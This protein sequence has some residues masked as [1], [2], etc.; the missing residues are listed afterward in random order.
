MKGFCP[1]A[2]R[3]HKKSLYISL[4]LFF[5][6]SLFWSSRHIPTSTQAF[7]AVLHAGS[8]SFGLPY[9]AAILYLIRLED[10]SDLLDSLASVKR[11]LPGPPWPVILFH[12]GDFDEEG[13]RIE[14]VDNVYNHL[15]ANNASKEFTERIEF[16]KLDWRLPEGISPDVNVVNPVFAHQWPGY[17]HMCSFFSTQIFSHPRLKDLT[18]YMRLDT[19]SLFTAPLCYDP[20]EVIHH[21]QRSYGYVFIGSEPQWVTSGMW[22][23]VQNYT[24]THPSVDKQLRLNNWK[25]SHRNE[26]GDESLDFSGYGT[27]LEIVNLGAFRRRDIREWLDAIESYPEGIYKWRWGDAPLRYATVQ[28]FFDVEKD[29]E[30]LCGIRYTHPWNE[31]KH[32]PCVPLDQMALP[33]N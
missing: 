4:G 20:I 17:H 12:T 6:F 32:C 33:A 3:S 15:G 16:V 2:L 28:M 1:T 26:D 19:D 10:A 13:P 11:N 23:L 7:R 29:T 30:L 21:R 24:N 27:N 14:L 9:T 18:Y 25:W 8:N 5:L 22:A 31:H